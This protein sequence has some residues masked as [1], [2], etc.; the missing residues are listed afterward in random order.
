MNLSTKQKQTQKHGEQTRLVF[1][2]KEE[3]GLG[4][5]DQQ[6]QTIT[7]RM[8]KNKVQLYGTW[9]YIQSPRI[10]HN[11]KEYKKEYVCV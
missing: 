4:V 1:V 10:N 9:N 6:M 5:W 11:G 7:F 2:K 8:D 3:D